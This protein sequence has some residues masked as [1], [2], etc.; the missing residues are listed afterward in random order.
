MTEKKPA[1]HTVATAH[2]DTVWNWDFETTVDK[3]IKAT[4]EKNFRLFEKYPDYIFSF[5]GSRRYE[6]MEEYYP[7]H[8]EKL[9]KYIAEGKWFV[10]GSAYEN[11]D[12]NV[13]SPEALFRNIL[14][15]T[16]YF[17]KK[18]GKK[19]VDIY[20]P[21]CF[22]F[23]YALPSV[24]K[25]SGLIGFTT[26]KLTW[27]SAY[28]IPF[29]LGIWKGVDGSEVF[30]SLNSLKYNNTLS[31]VRKNKK[32]NRKLNNNIEKYGLPMTLVLHGTGDI[33]G[34]PT[35]RSVETVV[36]EKRRNNAESVDVEIS[37]A[38]HVFREMNKLSDEAKAKL[39][40][41]NNELV[42]TN[43]GAGCY[44]SRTVGKRWNKRNEQLA[45]AAERTCS[46]A[47]WLGAGRYPAEVLDTSWKRVIAHQF[48]DD[49]TGTSV[50][51]AY[52]RS[53]NDYML[54]LNQ[55][56]GEYENA[57]S[58]V[59]S[60]MTVP[61]AQG[62]AVVVS[63][64][65]DMPVLDFA[66]CNVDL[67]KGTK[68]VKVQDENGN[69]VPSQYSNG[70]VIFTANVQGNSLSVYTVT[71]ASE[72]YRE[73]T[74]LFVSEKTLE[75]RKYKI[76]LNG[77]GDIASIF[78]KNLNKELL[79]APISMD[80]HKYNGHF[81]FPAWE[82][83]Y[84]EVSAPPVGKASAPKIYIEESGSAR[85]V[86]KTVR[87]YKESVFTQRII[88]GESSETV[89]I[90]N[91]IE[92]NCK[93]SLLKTP[94]S[95]TVS[96]EQAS[97]DLGVGVIKRGVNTP[98]LYEVPAQNW[99]DISSEEF[100]V[101]VFSE[102]KYGWDH[103][104]ADTL[105]LTGIHTPEFW[106]RPD[107]KQHL[108]DLG[109]NRYAFGI[110]SHSGEQLTETQ[111]HGALFSRPLCVFEA[112]QGNKGPLPSSFT[113]A[114]LNEN[115]VMIKAIKKEQNG[116]RTVVRFAELQGKE[117]KN[118]RLKI[119]DGVLSAQEILATEEYVKDA[120]VENGELV[121]DI[122]PYAPKSFALTLKPFD[123]KKI[124][125]SATPVKIPF[126]ENVTSSFE[127]KKSGILA[128]HTIPGELFPK[129]VYCK[130]TAFELSSEKSNALSCRGQTIPLPEG[131]KSVS[132]LITSRGGDK[133]C[134][135]EGNGK[136]AVFVPDC[137]E[138]I[139]AWDLYGMKEK[140]YVKECTLAYE[141][142]HTHIEGANDVARQLWM[143]R[144]DVPASRTLKLPNDPDI[145]I[146]AANASQTLPQRGAL[147]KL[148]DFL[149]KE[150]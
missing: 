126:N 136:T 16:D 111:H 127:H 28:G 87:R 12:V 46:A 40:L 134:V 9:K 106:Y 44:T 48:H 73:E 117:H 81:I 14:Y 38:D 76:K 92:W 65:V 71:P 35:D 90:E 101:S 29:D 86:I 108:L 66:E 89:R 37:S 149:E 17:N 33:G 49:I 140:G 53:W 2:L 18:F 52:K 83:D 143:F 31:R 41:W 15:G 25:H 82:L 146:F 137:F 19:S 118:V 104:T 120:K 150:E 27:S 7:S 123:G 75:N 45:D 135:F 20:L 74:G 97:Y 13:P 145:I 60:M 133:N 105:R 100:G 4:L 88:L 85:A 93:R 22:G 47:A 125:A 43:H 115:G 130:D 98:N 34:S 99:A 122:M 50:Q 3:Y 30:A 139:G 78:D 6:L 132:L 63:N 112:L 68:C 32:V 36:R 58:S 91:E 116:D 57:V 24:M 64:T 96:N 113:F 61:E 124:P 94:F 141:I 56:A 10:T 55:F 131:T 11:G 142:T 121:F 21:D 102:C 95:F 26:Q 8:F 144:V 128:G 62:I 77:N 59:A 148:Y 51:R 67:P 109:K 138:A 107:S 1:I 84:K 69:E 79:S 54:S 5:E 103:P 114:S 72:P 129:K 110:F 119:G 147:N 39:P 23:G 80:V 42:L 70:K